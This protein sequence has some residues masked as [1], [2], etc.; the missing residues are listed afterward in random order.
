MRHAFAAAVGLFLVITAVGQEPQVLFME[1]GQFG[2]LWANVT[3]TSLRMDEPYIPMVIAVQNSANEPVTI[4]RAAIRMIGP[5]GTRYPV[6]DL[7]EVRKGYEKGRLDYRMFNAAG[8]PYNV[9]YRQRRLRE[10][11]FF[12]D[13]S[14]GRTVIDRVVLRRNDALVDLVY[15]KRPPGF[16]VGRPFILEAHPEGWEVPTRLGIRIQ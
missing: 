13:M 12:P 9:W 6:A 15:F 10:S 8:I 2:E 5:E 7:K 11:N 14:S 16:A 1:K 4:D 3:L